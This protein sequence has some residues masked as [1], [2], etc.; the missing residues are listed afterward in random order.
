MKHNTFMISDYNS[1]EL[2]R[3]LESTGK[4]GK[5][6]EDYNN[7]MRKIKKNEPLPQSYVDVAYKLDKRFEITNFLFSG[8]KSERIK[9]IFLS[10]I[11]S[12][13]TEIMELIS[14]VFPR[15]CDNYST[16]EKLQ[17]QFLQLDELQSD[18]FLNY[19]FSKQIGEFSKLQMMKLG[20]IFQAYPEADRG[21]L[22]AEL[23]TRSGMFPVSTSEEFQYALK[24][25]TTNFP[26]E[27][28]EKL[29]LSQLQEGISTEELL[30]KISN[31]EEMYL[32]K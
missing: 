22:F 30:H 16:I 20:L 24:V 31:W 11:Y 7:L 4:N 12:N 23:D 5:S 13:L 25:A 26:I 8:I 28:F 29:L 18:T 19:Y 6:D 14:D 32:M 21:E 10:I 3:I 9:A 1:N 2:L 15:L 27:S 17:Q